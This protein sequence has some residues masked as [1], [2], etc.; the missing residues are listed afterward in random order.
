MAMNSGSTIRLLPLAMLAALA[1]GCAKPPPP[2]PSLSLLGRACVEKPDLA[3]ANAVPLADNKPVSV[4]LDDKTPCIEAPGLGKVAYVAFSLPQSNDEYILS[5]TSVPIGEGRF[6]PRLA[7]LDSNGNKLRDIPAD[8][9]MAHGASL[10]AGLRPHRGERY[11]IVSSDPDTIGQTNSQIMDGTQVTSAYAA[12]AT[13]MVH[14]G[15][16]SNV[17]LTNAYNGTVTVAAQPI[18]KAK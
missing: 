13:V 5:V 3:S 4:T 16:E 11:L 6:S 12:G 2:V 9:F 18:P 17:T 15:Y 8:M 7:L 10:H 14:T 1:G